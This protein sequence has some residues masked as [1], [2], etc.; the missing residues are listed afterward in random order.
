MKGKVKD[1]CTEC[2]RETEYIL[3]PVC[4]EKTIRGKKYKFRVMNAVCTV[5]GANM[6]PRGLM[7]K[8]V[9][10]IDQQYRQKEN[11]V[12]IEE[13]DKLMKLYNLNKSSLSL[14]LGFGEITIKRYLNGQ[15]PSKEYSD[16][17]RQALHSTDYMEKMLD[18][19][20]DLL[21]DVAYQKAKNEI[22]NIRNSFKKVSPKLLAVIYTLF[23]LLDEITPLMLQKLLYY[24]QGICMATT[25]RELFYEDCEAWVHGP[26]YRSV[27]DL[28]RDF[29]YNPIDD[30]RF[31]LFENL[32]NR[33][34]S[35]EKKIIE[36]IANTFGSYGGKTLERITHTEKPWI[37]ARHGLP[38]DMGSDAVI[39]KKSIRIFF[40]SLAE[41][42]DFQTDEGVKQYISDKLNISLK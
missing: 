2:R 16:R 3:K 6:C 28:F 31:C 13:I 22:E 33:L 24:A 5:C 42:Y 7:D 40:D 37:R 1:F 38:D 21:T 14:A 35:T 17:I 32:A 4:V 15:V 25:H 18:E 39:D 11:I 26:V 20:K 23:M 29:H 8:N 9:A 19:H 12:T 34:D 27:Y 36:R 41:K 10:M 30:L